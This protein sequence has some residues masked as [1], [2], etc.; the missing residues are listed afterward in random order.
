MKRG[1]ELLKE[2]RGELGGEFSSEAEWRVLGDERGSLF[3]R[4]GV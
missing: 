4:D 1:F 3:G 2:L